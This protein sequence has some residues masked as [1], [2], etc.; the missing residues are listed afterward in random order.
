MYCVYMHTVP[1]GKVYIGITSQEPS[2]RWRK[3]EGY[4][5]N[6][7]FYFAIQ[8][9]GWEN[10]NHEILYSGLSKEEACDKEKEVVV[11]IGNMYQKHPE[12]GAFFD[13]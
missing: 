7:A 13:V 5:T 3:G 4:K 2:R 1:N 12:K 10:I 8:K 9:Y 11:F 6:K